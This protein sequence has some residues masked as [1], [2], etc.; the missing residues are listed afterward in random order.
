MLDADKAVHR[1]FQQSLNPPSG[2]SSELPRAVFSH[3][4]L[5]DGS[6]ETLI[7]LSF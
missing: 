3:F 2:I 4:D 7:L 6:V 5:E 1:A